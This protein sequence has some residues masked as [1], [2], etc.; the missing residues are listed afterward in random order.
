MDTIRVKLGRVESGK[1]G[2]TFAFLREVVFQGEELARLDIPE[3]ADAGGLSDT[4]GEHQVLYR[5]ADGRLVVHTEE[6]SRWQGE[7]SVYRL[8]EVTEAD[9][10][11][12][13]YWLIGQEADF[14][15][16][17]TLDEAL[18]KDE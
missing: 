2:Q 11:T 9:L 16:P 18:H 6:W 12:G 14:T 10:R 8:A 15:R 1:S 17:L 4:R 5:A 7:P 13:D 3:L